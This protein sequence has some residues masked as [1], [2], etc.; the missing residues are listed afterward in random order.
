VTSDSRKRG[1]GAPCTE[2]DPLF[3]VAPFLVR[4]CRLSLRHHSPPML[5]ADAY[6]GAS[7]TEGSLIRWSAGPRSHKAR[8]SSATSLRREDIDNRRNAEVFAST[9]R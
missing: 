1:M 7:G 8:Q 5:L 2:N 9:C 6:S 4:I 3:S